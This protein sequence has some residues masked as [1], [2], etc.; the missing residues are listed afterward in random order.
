MCIKE[1]PGACKTTPFA[2]TITAKNFYGFEE[3]FYMTLVGFRFRM[4]YLD[5]GSKALKAELEK[6]LERHTF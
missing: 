3:R 2:Q 1:D 5:F 4:W 6:D